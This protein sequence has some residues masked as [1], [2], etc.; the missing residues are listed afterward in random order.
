MTEYEV[1]VTQAIAY[2]QAKEAP[3]DDM[4]N[5]QKGQLLF[6][7]SGWIEPDP[8]PIYVTSLYSGVVEKVHILEGQSIKQGEI[9]ATLI[10]EDAR[11][12]LSNITL[13][14][15]NQFRGSNY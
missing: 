7:A 13:C 1:E 3:I 6:Q 11:L 2:P 14:A 12:V 4:S 9:I 10:D 5:R 15:L 8:F